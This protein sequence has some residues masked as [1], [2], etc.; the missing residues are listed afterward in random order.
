MLRRLST[1]A[2]TAVLALST[3]TQAAVAEGAE[4]V[5]HDKPCARAYGALGANFNE[6]LDTL[7][8]RE[9]REA[10]ARWVC[11]RP[12]P[13]GPAATSRDAATGSTASARCGSPD[14]PARSPTNSSGLLTINKRLG[15][16]TRRLRTERTARGRGG[17]D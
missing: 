4:S 8:F 2:M 15:T 11:T 9:L 12:R 1:L 6:N 14:P 5:A 3:L 13:C 7:D 16:L 17:R 10:H